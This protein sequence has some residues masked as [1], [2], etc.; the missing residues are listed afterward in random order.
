MTIPARS[1]L[2]IVLV[3]SVGCTDTT[4]PPAERHD[5]P[6]V[7]DQAKPAEEAKP[8][9]DVTAA[10]KL[11]PALEAPAAVKAA[12]AAV[13][14]LS[15]ENP[16][17][18]ELVEKGIQMPD[19]TVIKLPAPTL[20]NGMDAAAQKAAIKK[21]M[22]RNCTYEDFTDTSTQAPFGLK[23]KTPPSRNDK[24]TIRTVDLGFVV[25]GKWDVLTSDKFADGFTK[26]N[27]KANTK[28]QG[29]ALKKSGFLSKEEMAKRSLQ[30]LT[31]N[32]QEDRYFFSTFS[33]FDMVEV[34][35]TRYAVLSK[36]PNA[37][38]LAARLDP[39]FVD[40][41]EYPNQWQPID[42]DA[43]G[44]PVL[45]KKQPY[46]GAGFYLKITR[47]SEPAGAIFF[48]FHSAFNEPQGWF[49]GQPT[50][51]QKLP[52]IAKFQVEQF[53]GKLARASM[54]QEEEGEKKA[55]K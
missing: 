23:I 25:H 5:A 30:S 15:G 51:R 16:V 27:T 54:K 4:P 3:A 17:L 55:E 14:D 50:L 42:K 28:N 37:I 2:L 44:N 8:K 41:P 13:A 12:P 38:A 40:D 1:L 10:T 7:A 18:V 20:G 48:E 52:T 53:R 47:L 6:V 26:P 9:P 45:G 33:L 49:D 22:P 21:I 32:G 19:G 36:T 46:S 11:G 24:Y 29:G 43:L 35:A 34:S 39:R 31:K